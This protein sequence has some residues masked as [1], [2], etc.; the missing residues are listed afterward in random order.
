MEVSRQVGRV[1]LYLPAF[2]VSVIS[3][4]ITTCRSGV[5]AAQLGVFGW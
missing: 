4:M 1:R 3:I 5:W 2:F